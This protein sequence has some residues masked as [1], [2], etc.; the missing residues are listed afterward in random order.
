MRMHKEKCCNWKSKSCN[1]IDG[2]HKRSKEYTKMKN[3]IYN[4]AAF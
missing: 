4:A 2:N 3:S 1:K